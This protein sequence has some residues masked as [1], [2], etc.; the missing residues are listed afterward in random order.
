IE[1]AGIQDGDTITDTEF[2]VILKVWGGERFDK[3]TVYYRKTSDSNW[4]QLE[5]FKQQNKD[6][7]DYFVWDLEE[8]EDGEIELRVVMQ[9]NQNAKAEKTIKLVVAKPT[10]TP[11]PTPTAT[12][13]PT[14]TATPTATEPATATFTPTNTP[15]PSSTPT[16]T[17]TPTPTVTP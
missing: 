15:T 6:P 12:V 7:K 14:I 2:P 17:A 13:T 4:T 8:V 3:F 5:S 16:P 10:P 11:T 1:F 9:G